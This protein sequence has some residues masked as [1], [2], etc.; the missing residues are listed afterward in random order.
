MK[1]ITRIVLILLVLSS[2]S[3]CSA[4]NPIKVLINNEKVSFGNDFIERGIDIRNGVKTYSLF[5]KVTQKEYSSAQ[6]REFDIT[7]NGKEYCGTDFRFVEAKQTDI[8]NGKQIEV[9]TRGDKPEISAV[10]LLLTYYIY[11][12]SPVVRK[13]L[14]LTNKGGTE[15]DITN[16]NMENI[17]LMPGKDYMPNVYANYGTNITRVPYTGDY[18]DPAILLY[19]EVDQE[20]VILGNESPGILKRTDCYSKD[21]KVAIGM[22]R[23][24]DDYPFKTTVK[25]GGSFTSPRSFLLVTKQDK[26]VDCF[27]KD[28]APFIR[29][30]LGVKLFERESYPLFYYCT[31]IPFKTDIN[32]N[33][34]KQLA[35]NLSDTGVEMLIIDDGWQD[36]SGDYNSHPERF[37]NGIEKTCE[38]IYSKGLKP[39]L[40]FTI[41]SINRDS[42]IYK[43][44]PEW[45]YTAKD[46]SPGN[47]Y[48]LDTYRVTM[49]MAT[50]WYDY[51]LGKLSHYIETCRLGYI[52]LDFALTSSAYITDKEISG[53]YTPRDGEYGYKDHASSYW[54]TYRSAMRLFDDL[55]R[56][57]PE[58]IIDCTFEAWG[59]F[60]L[61]DYA[62]VQHA[63]V[64]WLTNYEFDVPRGP[65]SIRQINA[66]RSRVIPVPTMMVGNQLIDSPMYKFT[67]HSLASGV[68]LMC[69][70]P[71]NLSAEQ[72]AWYKQWSSWF[73]EM[74]KK[75]QYTRFY[76]R[77]DVFDQPTMSNWDGAYRFNDEK[78][79]GVLFF[80]RNGNLNENVTFP[81][82]VVAANK[83]YKV[84][85][86][87]GGKQWGIY[88]GEDLINKG[89]SI[90]IPNQYEAKVIGIEEVK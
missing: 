30:N 13:Q 16:L 64:D 37:P 24:G 90:T 63:D 75:Y 40:W 87:Y 46:G 23:I 55:K 89:L 49:S 85:E 73:K 5:N 76:F 33:L 29:K 44:H 12:D 26:W 52:K 42:K 22:K 14:S 53:D 35:D 45:A 6:S 59:K 74:D 54:S 36:N 69:G 66:E 80:F 32:E 50:P 11:K 71:R 48:S 77:S 78:G 38:Y 60:H 88:K 68:Q 18:Y 15:I 25:S 27:D 86:P 47:V 56:K 43:E 17:H 2:G 28:L 62:L 83:S 34:V 61:I 39:G 20:G 8:P 57:Y 31:W 51:I 9:F 1:I 58:L 70:D 21:H 84:Y 41:A 67:Y 7:I 19:N 81:V 4:D 82:P 79:G 65:I 72:K 3:V 10:E